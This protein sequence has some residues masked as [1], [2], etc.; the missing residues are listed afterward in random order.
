MLIKDFK[1]KSKW[2]L[3]DF[4]S[5]NDDIISQKSRARDIISAGKRLRRESSS[6][7]DVLIKEKMDELKQQSDNISKLS[8][9]RLSNIEQA[10]PLAQ[11]F[12]ETHSDLLTWFA[13][14]EP[15]MSQLDASAITTEQIKEQQD[16]VRVS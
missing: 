14:S 3:F 8:A 16:D 2:S 9:D 4:Q 7:D 15:L 13:E 12:Q 1:N 10:M 5:L 6:E 11:H